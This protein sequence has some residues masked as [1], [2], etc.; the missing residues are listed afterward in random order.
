LRLLPFIQPIQNDQNHWENKI[1]VNY[2]P[3]IA[4]RKIAV[5]DHMQDMGNSRPPHEDGFRDD[6]G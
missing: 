3:S 4:G 2:D 6:E 5:L 1:P